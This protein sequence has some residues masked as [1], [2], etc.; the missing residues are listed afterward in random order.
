MKLQ[1]GKWE[2]A[3][4]PILKEKLKQE[5]FS[6][7][8]INNVVLTSMLNEHE[9]GEKLCSSEFIWRVYNFI[10]WYEYVQSK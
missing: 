7:P 3:L 4:I 6:D 9:S 8:Y 2:L 10:V 1:K 5:R